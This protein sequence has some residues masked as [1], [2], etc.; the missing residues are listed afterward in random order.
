MHDHDAADA[1]H[2]MACIHNDILQLEILSPASVTVSKSDTSVMSSGTV[3]VY[4]I[5][6]VL[7]LGFGFAGQV[8]VNI[9]ANYPKLNLNQQSL[10]HLQ[11]LLICVCL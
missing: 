9:T 6:Q 1:C 10:V 2:C 5:G 11:E 3:R 4:Q 8:L 7:G